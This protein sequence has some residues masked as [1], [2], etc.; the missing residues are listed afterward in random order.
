MGEHSHWFMTTFAQRNIENLQPSWR[1]RFL[2]WHVSLANRLI[3][4]VI[5]ANQKYA[6]VDYCLLSGDH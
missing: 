6:I 5:Q 3:L 2:K 4:I 1:R